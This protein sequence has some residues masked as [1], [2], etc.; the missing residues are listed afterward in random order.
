[1]PS[2]TGR[3]PAPASPLATVFNQ[4]AA[5]PVPSVPAVIRNIAGSISGDASQNAITA[6]NGAPT[7]SSAAMNGI[8]SQEQNGASPPTAQPSTAHPQLRPR[9]SRA[10]RP[11]R[12]RRTAQRPPR[13]CSRRSPRRC[14]SHSRSAG[15]AQGGSP[16]DPPRQQHRGI[17]SPIA[18]HALPAATAP[19]G[20]PREAGSPHPKQ[21]APVRRGCTAQRLRCHRATLHRGTL[22]RLPGHR[23][24]W[25]VHAWSAP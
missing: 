7:A 10:Q 24:A 2:P 19:R 18:S 11:R 25:Q 12:C 5:K 22:L 4:A 13:L 21:A 15:T 23:G 1:M 8:T 16:R 20:A 9:A 14:S 3:R 17:R 6:D